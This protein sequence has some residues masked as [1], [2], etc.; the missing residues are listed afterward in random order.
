MKI[1]DY[2]KHRIMHSAEDWTVDREYFDP[3]FNYLIH[4]FEPGGFWTAVLANDWFAAIQHSHPANEVE[5]L[6][7]ACGWIQAKW[8][9]ESYGSYD[10]VHGWSKLASFTRRKLLEE[11]ALIYTEREEVDMALRGTTTHAPLLL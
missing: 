6:K 7:R 1:T 8:P 4:G 2:S 9:P 10:L 5:N 3:L 11:A